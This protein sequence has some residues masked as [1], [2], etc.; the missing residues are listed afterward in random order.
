MAEILKDTTANKIGTGTG[1]LE[2]DPAGT[3]VVTIN[4]GILLPDGTKSEPA[5]RLSDDDNTGMYSPVNDSISLTGN[6]ED[7]LR[8]TGVASAVNYV[9]V[10][11]AATGNDLLIEAKGT[12]TNIDVS[13]TGKGTGTVLIN[14]L[15]YP[16]ADGTV[17]QVLKTDGSGSLDWADAGA[18]EASPLTTKGDLYTYTTTD[19]R[20]AVGSFGQV[21]T[22]DAGEATGVKWANP[23]T[24]GTVGTVSSID[25][26][27][28]TGSGNANIDAG[29]FV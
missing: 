21:L 3:E 22:V 29:S 11:N 13:L 27:T 2:L 7:V 12:D 4:N 18:G 28:I 23:V 26:G 16:T 1:G 19:A 5:I 20:L 17:D 9:E 10:T 8:A 6:G 25:F 14:S 15:R 24:G